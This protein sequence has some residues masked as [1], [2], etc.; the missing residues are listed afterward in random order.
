MPCSLA[1]NNLVSETGYVNASEVQGD[2]MAV[3]AKVIY[4]GRGMVVS[5]GVDDDGELK[6]IDFSGIASLAEALKL[7]KSLSSLKYACLCMP[8]RCH[9]C[10]SVCGPHSVRIASSP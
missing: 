5:K 2:S 10:H 1:Q 4:Q 7:N 6:M 8:D 3:G 9:M